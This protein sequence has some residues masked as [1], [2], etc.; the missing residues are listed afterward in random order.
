MEEGECWGTGKRQQESDRVVMP[1]QPAMNFSQYAGMVT[2]DATAG[3][4]FFY[5]FVE[6]P[7]HASTKPVTLWLNRGRLPISVSRLLLLF[8]CTLRLPCCDGRFQCAQNASEPTC[9]GACI[10]FQKNKI[11]EKNK[12]TGSHP[13]YQKLT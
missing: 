1:E 5:F 6:S 8:P 4:Q 13:G 7:N 10:R 9:V 3:R 11:V 12:I 2:V